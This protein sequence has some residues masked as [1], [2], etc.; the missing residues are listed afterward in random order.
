MRA[1][2]TVRVRARVTRALL[3][4]GMI[5]P[6]LFIL[7]FLLEDATRPGFSAWRNYVS[8]LSTGPGGWV[9][10]LNFLVCGLLCLGF[11][12]ALRRVFAHSQ[13]RTAS[14]GGPILIGLFALG[15]IAAGLFPTDPALGYPPGS[16]AN[17]PQTLHGTVHGVAGLVVFVTLSAACFVIARRFVGDAAWSGWALATRITGAV[18]LLLFVVSVGG[19][20][21]TEAGHWPNAPLGLLERVAIIVGFGWVALLAARLLRQEALPTPATTEGAR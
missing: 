14:L 5:G 2:E 1:T 15:L 3:L 13:N 4:G 12:L 10:V 9:Q 17:G 20:P 8:Q 19:G 7:V 16:P 21:L 6:P 18:V 11:A